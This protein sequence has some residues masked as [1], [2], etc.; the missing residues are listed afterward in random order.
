MTG[1]QGALPKGQE[2]F[3]SPNFLLAPFKELAK[4]ASN[5]PV[6]AKQA[7]GWIG[8]AL[9]EGTWM[10]VSRD[11]RDAFFHFKGRL[12]FTVD[13]G[14]VFF[15]EGVKAIRKMPREQQIKFFV[16]AA[17]GRP[18]PSRDLQGLRNKLQELEDASWQSMRDRGSNVAYLENHIRTR[19]KVPPKHSAALFE[20]QA[21]EINKAVLS[22]DKGFMRHRVYKDIAEGMKDGGVPQTTNL[23]EAGLLDLA[24]QGQ[25][26]AAHDLLQL[27]REDGRLVKGED[28]ASSLKD[29]ARVPDNIVS[30]FF[31]AKLARENRPR[32]RRSL[33]YGEGRVESA[34]ELALA[35]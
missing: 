25:W 29:P 32:K 23:F 27:Q 28:A 22:G 7:F 17:A 10:N 2:G 20:R 19:W 33:V 13:L 21:T 34:S 26:I 30:S 4:Y 18:M 11:F 5:A 3:I 6:K 35:G 9:T 31:P 16:D 12:N 1:K 14:R 24:T 15:N 8:R